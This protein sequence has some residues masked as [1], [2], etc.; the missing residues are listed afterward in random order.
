MLAQIVALTLAIDT[1]HSKASFSVQHIFVERV[2]G[3]VP[4][5]GGIVVLPPDSA[6]P[7][8]LT[9][10]LD[11]GK[12]SSGDRDRDASLVSIDFFN[13]KA[14]PKWTFASTKITPAG[15]NAFGLDG[16][17]TIHGVTAPEHLDVTIRGDPAH[18][19][20]HA[21]G[22]IDRGDFH[23][24]VTRLDPVIGKTVDVTLDITLK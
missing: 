13:V 11:P 8:E 20:Y 9:A 17:L 15:A 5:S 23:M 12:V 16:T 22:H 7:Q 4:I 21:V 18:R 24:P 19:S 3:T 1:A 2:T 6:I 10:E 14:F